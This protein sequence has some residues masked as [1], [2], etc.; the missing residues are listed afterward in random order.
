VRA[1]VT[2]A[3]GFIGG[4]LAAKLDEA[5]W[6]VLGIDSFSP[7]YDASIKHDTADMLARAHGVS[8]VTDDL[9][10]TLLSEI[11]DDGVDVVFHL[12]AQ[13][14]VRH[15]WEDF[16][17][18]LADNVTATHRV[19]GACIQARRPPRLVFASSSS[20]YGQIT[21]TVDEQAPTRPHSPY[22]VT[23]LAA[24]AL[25][26][27]YAHNFGLHTVSLR[28]FTVYGPRQ[29]PD[30]AFHKLIRAGLTGSAFPVYGDGTQV[31]A[32]TYVDDVVAAAIRA[33]SAPIEPGAVLNISGGS[34]CTLRAAIDEVERAL[35]RTIDVRHQGDQ[36]GDV[37][38]TD[39]DISLARSMLGWSPQTSL[40]EGIA[41][42]VSDMRQ[43]LLNEGQRATAP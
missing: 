1:L 28:L 25:C 26:R 3:A 14:G 43:A 29:R 13:P 18:Y 38:I 22:G 41:H 11:L 32:F 33:A 8:V 24:E 31:R 15:S 4:N 7:Y 37:H 23:K 17:T 30:M 21:S 27:A 20:V 36:A 12:A 39:A 35:G 10:S 16:G 19:L 42:Q 5:G 34:T 40:K 6:T 2:G 9:R